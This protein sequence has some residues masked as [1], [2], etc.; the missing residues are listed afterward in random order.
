MFLKKFLSRKQP[1]LLPVY[2]ILS[3][4]ILAFGISYYFVQKNESINRV[5]K[6]LK[7]VSNLK[8]QEINHWLNERMADARVL[9]VDQAFK[10]NLNT[11]LKNK[12]DGTL[13]FL[14][15]KIRDI[16]E[17]YRYHKVILLD[18]S[19]TI[20]VSTS[21]LSHIGETTKSYLKNAAPNGEP[22][23]SDL[24]RCE[25][26]KQTHLDIVAAIK[27]KKMD[28]VPMAYV[29]LRTDTET[30]LFEPMKNWAGNYKTSETILFH[31]E[32]DSVVYLNPLKN[33]NHG[34]QSLK[35]P[36]DKIEYATANT[37]KK[38]TGYF[39]GIDYTGNR[40]LT[41][42]V[43]ISNTNWFLISKIEKSEIIGP[44]DKLVWI[45][46]LIAIL[47][48]MLMGSILVIL[49]STSQKRHYLELLAKEREK[50]LLISHFEY[51]IRYA[52][53]I[54]ILANE[55]GQIIEANNRA[56]KT[57]QYTFDEITK[58]SIKDLGAFN[59]SFTNKI[60]NFDEISKKAYESVH[61]KKNG[62]KFHVEIGEKIIEIDSQKYYQAIIRDVSERV[63]LLKTLEDSNQRFS[64]IFYESPVPMIITNMANK[65]ITQ[66]NK[67]YTELTGYKEEDLLK[68]TLFELD[69]IEDKLKLTK[70]F[71][72]IETQGSLNGFEI[73]LK[74][75][76]GKIHDILAWSKKLKF[77]KGLEFNLGTAI[78]IS[79]LREKEQKLKA[80]EQTLQLFVEYAP[81]A[82]AMFDKQMN[83]MAVSWRFL[84][85]YGLTGQNVIGRSHYE[86]FPEIGQDWKNVH[87]RCLSGAIE[88]A[89]ED[90]FPRADGRFDYVRWEIHPWRES[91]GEIGGIFLFSEVITDRKLAE[92]ELWNREVQYRNLANS[93][94][95][96]IWTSGTDR[97]C[98]FFNEPW[99]KFTG[100][101]LEQELGNGWMET[102]HPEDLDNLLDIQTRAFEQRIP[103]KTD[104]R[105][106][107][108]QGEYRW[109]TVLATPNYNSSGE[110]IGYI[111]HCF[112]ITER[113]VGG[114]KLRQSEEKYRLLAKNMNDVV[115]L[116]NIKDFRF[117][118]VSPS[119]YQLRG[120]TPEEVMA[121]S[122]DE[123]LTPESR[124]KVRNLLIETL[125]AHKKGTPFRPN[126][127]EIEQPCKDGSIVQTE[128]I[129]NVIYD[130][131][132]NPVQ[133]I[134]VTRNITERKKYEHALIESEQFAHSVL[135]GLSA[136]IAIVDSIGKILLVNESWRMF[137][138]NNPPVLVNV[139]EGANYLDACYSAT[140]ESSY[141]ARHFADM[142]IS[143][144][145][146]KTGNF[147]FEYECHSPN[148]KRWFT[149][150]VSK[151]PG[152]GKARAIIA[153]ENIT[154]QKLSEQA[155]FQS[156][157]LHRL[158]FEGN[159]IPMWV[160]DLETL[161]FLKV[162]QA[163][164]KRYGYTSAEFLNMTLKDIRPAEDLELLT[165]NIQS[166][167]SISQESGPWRH[168]LKNGE[169]I[170]V[171]IR[172]HE[173]EFNK[174]PARIVATYDITEK[175]KAHESM[176]K[177]E[178]HFRTLFEQ[179]IDGIFIA[180]EGGS[181]IDVNNAGCKM[182]GYTREEIIRLTILDLLP[183]E[184]LIKLE[185]EFEI[186]MSGKVSNRIWKFKRKDKRIFIGE[187]L[188]KK[189]PDG[190]IQAFVR[191]ITDKIKADE[192][193]LLLNQRITNATKA[194]Q[195]G[196]W[197]WDIE[198][199]LLHW[200]EQM[201]SLYGTTKEEFPH[202]YEAWL[203]GIH[204]EDRD[205][206]DRESMLAREGLKEYNTEFRVVWPDGS[207]HFIKAQGEVYR[208]ENKGVIR[209]LGVNFD[210]T[211]SKEYEKALRLSEKN[212]KDL[213]NSMNE[214]IWI[215]D[216]DGN[217]LDVND[218]AIRETGYTKEELQEMGVFGIDAF[219]KKEHIYDLIE[220]I[221][222]EKYQVFE[223]VHKTKNG[224]T[225]PVEISST[226]VTYQ[227]Q[228]AILSTARNIAERK[229]NEKQLR[230]QG[231]ALNAAANAIVITDI[232]GCIQWANRA[233][234]KLTGYTEDEL[235]GKNLGVL[236]KSGKQPA[237]FY[238]KL[239]K[240]ILSGE[241]WFGELI[242]RRKNGSL[243]FEE[244]SI[245]PLTDLY[246][247]ITHFISIKQDISER[248]RSEDALRQSETQ[249]SAIF[250]HSPVGI[251]MTHFYS[252]KILNVN[253]TFAT[254]HGFSAMELI[255]QTA[256][257][258]NL[259]AE[260]DQHEKLISNL[261][262]KG[263]C[264]NYEIK[265][266]KKN[267]EVFDMVVSSELISVGGKAITL[268]IAKDNTERK[269]MIENLKQ[270]EERLRSIAEQSLSVVWE[271]DASC[272]YT[273]ISPMVKSVW[274][275]RAEEIV[276]KK[277]FYDLHP[278][279]G[280]NKFKKEILQ[281]FMEKVDFRNFEN[282]ILKKDGSFIWVS[283]NGIPQLDENGNLK[284]YVGADID[285]TARKH[286]EE[287]AIKE[288]AL[289]TTLI[290]NLPTGVFIK[291]KNFRKII[292]NPI[293]IKDVRNHL[294][295]LGENP[296]VKITNKTD[297]E[298][299]PHEL[300]ENFYSEDQKVIN[301]GLA[302]ENNE[303]VL[304]DD[305]GGQIHK[306]ITKI[307]LLDN[308]NQIT[309]MIGVTTDITDRKKAEIEIMK[310]NRELEKRVA[311][312]TAELLDLYNNAPCGYHSLDENGFFVLVNDTELRWLGYEREDIINKCK[313]TELMTEESQ[314]IFTLIFPQFKEKGYINNLELEFV[315]KNGS[316]LPVL[317]TATVIYDDSG[318][319][320][321]SRSTLI[322]NTNRKE[323]EKM[324]QEYNTKLENSNKELE[325]FAYSVSHD[326]RAPLRHISGFIK[327]FVEKR[328]TALTNEE[329]GYLDI[330]SKSAEEMGN[331]IDALLSFSRLNKAEMQKQVLDHKSIITGIIPI[332]QDEILK[333]KIDIKINEL[334]HETGD[335]QLI[336]QVW[337]NLISNAIKYTGK[338]E[339]PEIE[340]GSFEEEG[341]IVFYVKDNGA[342]FNMKYADK[343]FGV[344]QRL[345][346]ARDFEGIGI[347]L[348]N[349]NRIVSR[350]GGLCWAEGETD[351]GATFYFSLPKGLK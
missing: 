106:K 166:E 238:E 134:G 143:V 210:I 176:I 186:L 237:S 101:S 16:Q 65:K 76:T 201:Y 162:N 300:A 320:L 208:D 148:E 270:S 204:H 228:E 347:G 251:I 214:T 298:V 256:I 225:F 301:N 172:S 55:K 260:P 11:F 83:Y 286:A 290:D 326:L 102:V 5:H 66:V 40:V 229:M 181:Y 187:V 165:Y 330:I 59:F 15:Q 272:T 135:N 222:E 46:S 209:M 116:I 154:K 23:V 94:M 32:N 150:R 199:N 267:G 200:D 261:K 297:F 173:F 236:V 341:E 345:H 27:S 279:E 247:T 211:K 202:A 10:L 105:I 306:L 117:E 205:M 313:A 71:E 250:N 234:T 167:N 307:P 182:M 133:V 196:I 53:D 287:I 4:A 340:I 257:D 100:R 114:E 3:L 325:A 339:N 120:Y 184:E 254:M 255:G 137:A 63:Q 33:G 151:F 77:D 67:A 288:K 219:L 315:R 281:I 268:C 19:H 29:I 144:I 159:P 258:L 142:L 44:L 145:N 43:Q 271:V 119:V 60:I 289:L 207:I 58:K 31:A 78:N 84:E 74:S 57:Y 331:L 91:S 308:N 226:L 351:K 147:E 248:K 223:S 54:I 253:P 280:R 108:A 299:Y 344:F 292:A 96:L 232:A 244:L 14:L 170:L 171:D 227:G 198:S 243:Y 128:V 262:E 20:L 109:V 45:I 95:S 245:T 164:I 168:L 61:I 130:E 85:D 206:A 332:F 140:G 34:D 126:P 41:Y 139:N 52:N 338:K 141:K 264:M 28:N 72:Q 310:L 231:A 335:L 235:L 153:H 305:D 309:G 69:I 68:K 221:L 103:V 47:S 329:M 285:I 346:K 110:F 342:G 160:Y 62:E 112:D 107:N 129:T 152:E 125:D 93:G 350:H 64:M 316:V 333:R 136:H 314:K 337:T 343:L 295:A 283:S 121:Q 113:I 311:E 252:G 42:S 1:W 274:G 242:N 13:Q 318:N 266:R 277:R 50:K 49:K 336:K 246:G 220:N 269:K 75:K 169:M 249:L 118:Y 92:I 155:V 6:E 312:R 161:K 146:G 191:D 189:L 98:N 39:E 178:E 97:L 212:Y 224:K 38:G 215:I 185:S 276:G 79:E 175:V 7:S 319:F 180:D 197:E 259:W 284:G 321:R 82:I 12:D 328:T 37:I 192:E 323:A 87:Q 26:C 89:E 322:D 230:I 24:Y 124:E 349:V 291:D 241:T 86:I 36:L 8:A 48:I 156:E 149:A 218:A 174:K 188:S 131:K 157:N 163:A 51:L 317:L 2:I 239:W 233:F 263:H 80:R 127:V 265:S 302:V 35:L 30:Q 324:I 22:I 327:H 138:E 179:A 275:Y 25:Q 348:A 334:H 294:K 304:Y 213:L 183:D 21:P 193:I 17:G 190:R 293:H 73:S 216:F 9:S 115:W 123:A 203:N 195:M 303:R 273:Y 99:L 240:T 111:G 158:L 88:K 217:L 90:T 81:A 194:A 177:S 18:S 56:L 70:G 282:K 278:K 132:G 296:E 104:Y 122:A